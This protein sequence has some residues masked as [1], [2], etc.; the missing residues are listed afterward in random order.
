MFI[1]VST[2]MRKY[3]RIFTLVIMGLIGVA[4]FA[5]AIRSQYV[6]IH[7]SPF[8]RG[9]VLGGVVALSFISITPEDKKVLWNN[10]GISRYKYHTIHIPK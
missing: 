10:R 3:T 5:N 6:Y 1:K 9:Y 7:Q 4:S 8:D 2:K